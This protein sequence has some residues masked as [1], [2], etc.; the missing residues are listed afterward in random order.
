MIAATFASCSVEIVRVDADVFIPPLFLVG[1]MGAGK[2]T[3]GRGLARAM[4]REFVD[5]DQVIET[6]CG[7]RIPTIF[8]LEG[9]AGFR[10]RE[11]HVLDEYSRKSGVVLATGGGVVMAEP[12][13]RILAERGRVLYLRARAEE[14]YQR[15]RYD[16]NRPL[17]RTADPLA[18]ITELLVARE[19]LYEEIADLVV[20]TGRMSVTRLVHRILP[21]LLSCDKPIT[22]VSDLPPLECL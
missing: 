22:P 17:L 4:G 14:L 18:K 12:N 21:L 8:E 13:R 3:I 16:R 7:V 6:R 1:M 2:T 15:T 9:E 10:A 20:D 19:P 5:I 11:A